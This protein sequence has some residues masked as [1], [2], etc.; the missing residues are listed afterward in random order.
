V[1][2]I[3]CVIFIFLCELFIASKEEWHK[4]RGSFLVVAMRNISLAFDLD[5]QRD[6]KG[7][8][9]ALPLP[10]LPAYSSYC[11]FP[12]TTVFGPFIT[13][14]E[15]CKFLHPT[16]LSVEWALRVLSSLVLSSV[17]LGLS[18]CIMPFLFNEPRYNK[19]LAAYSAAASFRFSHYFVSFLSQSSTIASGMGYTLNQDTSVSW[20][21]FHVVHP[22]SVEIPRSM[23]M[24]VTNWSLPMH[25]FL[26]NYV[27]KPSRYYFGQFS[28]ILLTFGASALLH[29]VNFQL[30]AV[31]LSL[32]LY[33]YI[34]SGTYILYACQCMYMCVQTHVAFWLNCV[35]CQT[36]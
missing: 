24:I 16:P 32:G 8:H 4:I 21:S 5:G 7:E 10:D 2:S 28:A 27:F 29:G 15:H 1:V 20:S 17:F 22:L 19:W 23:P 14:S 9:K 11:L 12:G 26:K 3:A 36:H 6:S 30:A 25:I 35:V 34:E 18:V 13:Y 33:A 31:L